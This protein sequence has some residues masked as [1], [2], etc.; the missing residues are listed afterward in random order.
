[1]EV[2]TVTTALLLALS[3]PLP[4]VVAAAVEV[5]VNSVPITL[6]SHEAKERLETSLPFTLFDMSSLVIALESS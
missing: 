5:D 3:V 2:V 1:V 4:V 6:S